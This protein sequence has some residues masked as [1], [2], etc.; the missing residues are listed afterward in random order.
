VAWIITIQNRSPEQENPGRD[1]RKT[2]STET[3]ILAPRDDSC[4]VPLILENKLIIDAFTHKL[5]VGCL[6][7]K[8]D[9]FDELIIK[10]SLGLDTT[11]LSEKKGNPESTQKTDQKPPSS[12]VLSSVRT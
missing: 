6:L 5:P 9:N 8:K 7:P 2:Y 1:L 4:A 12:I 3:S 10:I 11:V